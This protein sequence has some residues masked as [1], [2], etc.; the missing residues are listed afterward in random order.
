MVAYNLT[1][2]LVDAGYI[3]RTP[4]IAYALRLAKRALET[5]MIARCSTLC[6]AI[7]LGKIV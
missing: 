2:S 6:H 5:E 1:V 7:M 4:T 3:K